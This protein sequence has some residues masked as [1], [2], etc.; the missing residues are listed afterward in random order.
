MRSILVVE[1]GVFIPASKAQQ[2]AVAKY[3]SQNYDKFLV[4][5]DKGKKDVIQTAAT[6]QG[7]SLNK[8]VNEAID[9][10]MERDTKKADE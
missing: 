10:K 4:R 7:K 8:Y 9:E 2:K 5:T 3:E 1:G 6:E